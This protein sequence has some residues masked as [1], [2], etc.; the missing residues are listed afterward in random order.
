MLHVSSQMSVRFAVKIAN[1]SSERKT[2]YADGKVGSS[3]QVPIP[4]TDEEVAAV[5]E[6]KMKFR[7]QFDHRT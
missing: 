2:L 5:M 4:T 1:L 7:G 6:E 3:H